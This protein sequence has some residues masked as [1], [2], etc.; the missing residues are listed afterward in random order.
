[1]FTLPRQRLCREAAAE[2]ATLDLAWESADPLAV[3]G[4]DSRAG[5]RSP[6]EVASPGARMKTSSFTVHATPEQSLRWK[7]AAE[8]EGHRS[9]GTWLAM[10]ADAY[11][12]VR[13]RAGLP[14]P[15]AWHRGRFSVRLESGETVPVKGHLSP[16]FGSFAGT[17]EGPATYFGRHRHAL[18][19]L[20]GL[21]DHR[22][23]PA[24]RA[25]QGSSLRNRSRVDPWR[26]PSARRG[27]R[28]NGIAGRR[29]SRTRAAPGRAALGVLR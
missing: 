17:E 18:V 20:A 9:A 4:P 1:M 12:K 6:S 19:R 16:P 25:V 21:P 14:I 15:L 8:A 10:A 24:L 3:T 2:L 22:H 11:L 27:D 13:A 28:S 26:S 5:G 23:S 29:C 7:R